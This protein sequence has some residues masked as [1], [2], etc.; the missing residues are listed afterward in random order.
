MQQFEKKSGLFIEARNR[1]DLPN[2]GEPDKEM[3]F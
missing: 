2:E 3:E 1:E